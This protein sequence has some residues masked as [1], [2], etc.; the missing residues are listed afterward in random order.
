M[1]NSDSEIEY[2]EHVMDDYSDSDDSEVQP[3]PTYT[4]PKSMTK[5]VV[6]K[7]SS[8]VTEN[9]PITTEGIDETVLKS[10]NLVYIQDMIQCHCCAKYYN[11]S[12]IVADDVM[13]E[14]M[15]KHCLCWLS[16]SPETRLAFDTKCA[17]LY[18]FCIAEYILTCH[19]AHD[20]SKC[21]RMTDQGGCLLCDYNLNLD[22]PNILNREMLP[23]FSTDTKKIDD[24]KD[25]KTKGKKVQKIMIVD[26]DMTLHGTDDFVMEKLVI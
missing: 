8:P 9:V 12:L 4:L 3:N 15:C 25:P 19:E 20:S 23:K 7:S 17:S 2:D 21:T 18:G 14:Q 1:S 24:T 13:G 10:I 22:I 11:K 16:Y 6:K 5:T 26:N